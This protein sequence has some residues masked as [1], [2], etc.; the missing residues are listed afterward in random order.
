[1]AVERIL[2]G[3]VD[4]EVSIYYFIALHIVTVLIVW[5]KLFKPMILKSFWVWHKF[6]KKPW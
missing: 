6:E 3:I 4:L 1:M 2:K 5:D